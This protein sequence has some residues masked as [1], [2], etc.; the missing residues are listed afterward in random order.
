M[1]NA[2]PV[3]TFTSVEQSDRIIDETIEIFTKEWI[4]CGIC[5]FFV[6][7]VIDYVGAEATGASRPV[8]VLVTGFLQVALWAN[9]F[10]SFAGLL[11][12]KFP[13][14]PFHAT[15]HHNAILSLITIWSCLGNFISVYYVGLPDYR[16]TSSASLYYTG[17]WLIN[18]MASEAVLFSL[19]QIL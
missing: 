4:R 2:P 7:F 6:Y 5:T 1:D 8:N 15:P 11:A 19:V 13:H 9:R 16:M 18:I 17:I 10:R 12:N 3:G 14:R